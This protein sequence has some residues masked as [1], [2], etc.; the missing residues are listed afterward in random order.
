MLPPLIYGIGRGLLN[1]SF[2]QLPCLVEAEIIGLGEATWNNVHTADLA[3]AYIII[4]DR[5]LAVYGL[6]TKTDKQPSP[7]L[8]IG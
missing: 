1:R 2:I 5:P 7:Y 8:T 4:F 3:D 6:D